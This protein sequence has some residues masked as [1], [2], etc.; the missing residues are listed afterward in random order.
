MKFNIPNS[1]SEDII[2]DNDLQNVGELDWY[3]FEDI[4]LHEVVSG[5][6][7]DVNAYNYNQDATYDD[8]TCLNGL[9]GT[10]GPSGGYI[11]YD[12]GA[13]SEEWR[14]LEAAPATWYGE[15]D[16]SISWGCTYEVDGADSMGVGYGL[17]N[18]LDI[19][20]DCQDLNAASLSWNAEINEIEDWF[21]PSIEE[22]YEMYKKLH[23]NNLG[24]FNS[25][26]YWSS[27][28]FSHI[29]AYFIEFGRFNLDYDDC[30]DDNKIGLIM[31]DQLGISM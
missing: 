3:S 21:L 11:F 4:V 22:L 23:K 14:Y 31:L 2:G 6:C 19:V 10:I 18:T 16:P 24:D 26:Y 5:G 25:Q 9:L 20:S 30:G 12:R 1:L 27:S 13:G 28:E 29:G 17:Q 8:G 15:T 7:T